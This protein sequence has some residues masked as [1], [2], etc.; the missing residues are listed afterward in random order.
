MKQ[1]EVRVFLREV[2]R[3]F[4]QTGAVLPSS[5]SL[6]KAMVSQIKKGGKDLRILEVG[7]GTGVFTRTILR[8]LREEDHLDLVEMN[9]YFAQYLQENLQDSIC[10]VKI[11]SSSIQELSEA[12]KYDYIISG[13]PLNNCQPEVIRDLFEKLLSFL[14]EDGIL[15]YF[16]YAF[17]RTLKTPF[18]GRE[19]RKRLQNIARLLKVYLQKFEF[20]SE[21]VPLNIPPAIARHLCKTEGIR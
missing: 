6:A 15:S 12:R 18:V 4:S 2:L 8:Q 14:K 13:L 10:R 11:L 7:P 17:V 21:F 19:E 9:P 1:K 3:D 20:H 16:E 5:R